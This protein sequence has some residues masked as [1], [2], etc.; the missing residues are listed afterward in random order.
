[1]PLDRSKRH[2]VRLL[3]RSAK[4]GVTSAAAMRATEESAFWQAHERALSRSREAGESTQRIATAAAKQRA[5]VDSLA[6]R[7]RSVGVRAHELSSAFARVAEVFDRLGLVALNAGLEG[8]RLGESAGR[9]VLLVSDEVRTHALRG[10]E[11]VRDLSSALTELGADLAHL[12]AGFE[13]PRESATELAEHAALAAGAISE[14]ERALVEIEARARQATGSD[15]ETVRAL[16]AANTQA[17]ALMQTLGTLGTKLPPDELMS[18]LRPVLE[19]LARVIAE[20]ELDRDDA[21]PGS[22]GADETT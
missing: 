10:G 20:S 4:G 11:A 2:L 15:P 22:E 17:Q 3:R 7:S 19:P 14:A 16:S 6:D 9:A 12:N 8:A 18:A 21:A 13:S 5:A 1:M